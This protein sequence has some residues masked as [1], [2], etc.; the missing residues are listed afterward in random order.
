VVDLIDGESDD[1]SDTCEEVYQ[2]EPM[3][4]E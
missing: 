3:P 4:E 1:Y 2:T